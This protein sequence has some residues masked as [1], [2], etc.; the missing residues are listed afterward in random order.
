MRI[1]FLLFYSPL[2]AGL[3]TSIGAALAFF[4][5]EDNKTLLSL[6]MGFS[7]GVMIYVSFIEILKKSQDFFYNP[8][9]Q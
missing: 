7:A 2:F 4:S 8:A 6:G 5:K 3:S 9:F 1:T